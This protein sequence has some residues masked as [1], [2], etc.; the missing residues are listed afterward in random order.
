MGHGDKWSEDEITAACYLYLYSDK[1][2]VKEKRLLASMF[3]RTEKSI[4]AK[5]DNIA[6]FD[7]HA[8][9]KGKSVWDNGSHLD[10]VV[11]KKFQETPAYNLCKISGL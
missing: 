10:G 6:R 4:G 7:E 11:W 5:M 3:G 1:I 9:E 2:T 8:A